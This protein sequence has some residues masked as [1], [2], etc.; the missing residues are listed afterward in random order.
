MSKVGVIIINY[1][2]YAERF[3]SEC[4]DSLREQT[5]PKD[6]FVVYVVDNASEKSTQ[7]YLRR[8]YPEAKIIPRTD[9]NYSAAN[10]AGIVQAAKDGCELFVIANMD[11]YFDKNW[12]AE[13]VKAVE[14]DEKVGIAQSLIL[15]YPKNENEWRQPQIN[16]TGNVIHFL[17]FAFTENY[18]RPIYEMPQNY[19]EITGY[20]SGCSLIIKKEV[21]DK[22]GLYD[23]EYYMYHDDVEIGWRTRLAGYKI[24]LAPKSLVYHKY[25][26]TRSIRM[27]YYMERN[28]YLTIFSLYKLSTLLLLAPMAIF[29]ELGLLVY[30]CA[31]KKIIAK[32]KVINYFLSWRTWSWIIKKRRSTL[33][34]EEEANILKNFSGKIVFQ[35][36]DNPI[37][38]YVVNPLCNMYW[39][40]LKWII[41]WR[42]KL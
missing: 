29:I 38:K 25:E 2:D 33:R 30:C 20:A 3:L 26:F 12:L 32:L 27:F 7:E 21:L 41:V 10:N 40:M 6:K 4:R 5:F 42:C 24:V 37:L 19:P 28:R 23:E 34:N 13:L 17:G 15:L 22:I 9:G 16:S 35:E 36:I 39:A 18:R 11:T 14:F 31:T 1:K 8:Q